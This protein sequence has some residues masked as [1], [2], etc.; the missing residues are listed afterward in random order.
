[1]VIADFSGDFLNFDS[2]QDGD[3]CVIL[4]EGGVEYNDTLKK[5]MFNIQVELNGKK[6]TYSPNN[7]A[8]Q[9]LQKAYGMDS[10][11]WVGKKFE[12]LHIQGKMVIRTMK[13]EKI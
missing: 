1:M 5:E 9:E 2:T 12:I 4:N 7:K 11:N 3:I 6:K 10:K 13:A 8:G